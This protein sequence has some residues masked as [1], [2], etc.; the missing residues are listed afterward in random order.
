MAHKKG[1]GSSD[2]GRD[3][4]SKRL[5]VKLFG[6]QAARAG[7]IIVRQ[8]GTKFHPG[9]YVGI[10]RDHTLFALVDGT[11]QF[12]TKRLN[13]TFVSIMPFEE[14]Q[15]R[16]AKKP[17]VKLAETPV[18]THKKK[19]TPTTD[20]SKKAEVDAKPETT[21]ELAPSIEDTSKENKETSGETPVKDAIQE[22]KED[23]KEDT[24]EP[25]AEMKESGEAVTEE[26]KDSIQDVKE[27][28]KPKAETKEEASSKTTTKQS[29]AS[30]EESPVDLESNKSQLLDTLGTV[31]ASNK[32]DLKKI[33]GVGPKLEQTLNSLGIYSYEQVSK[34]TEKEYDLVDSLLT[35]FKG[36]AKRDNWAQ[37]A[38]DLM[39]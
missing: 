22:V 2:N 27:S 8:R 3:S 23:T 29:K 14:V 16:I 6:G 21:E 4:N 30:S 15:E 11:V 25:S 20:A 18:Q 5:G 31:D 33:K 24:A 39:K 32:D 26:P 28:S 37:Q 38:K 17:K 13:R 19:E 1:V 12:K 36:R 10:G 34:M 35:T 7:N 9:K